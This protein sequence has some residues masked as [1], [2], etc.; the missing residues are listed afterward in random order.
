VTRLLVR[1]HSERGEGM[2]SGLILLAG[3]LLPL[4]F[5]I[6]LFARLEQGKLA[7]DQA[8]REAVRAAALAPTAEQAEAA[9]QQA[10]ARGQAAS[11]QQLRLQLSGA[12]DRGA[13]LRADVQ[14]QIVLGHLPGVGDFG[15]ITLSAHASAPIDRYRSLLQTAGP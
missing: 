14:T 15:T 1:L 6:P 2:I 10:L 5:V 8:A 11:G 7:A 9:A 3:V 12:F 4:L 13:T